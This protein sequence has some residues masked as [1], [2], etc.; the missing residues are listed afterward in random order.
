M[1][2][3]DV[4]ILTKGLTNQPYSYAG[5]KPVCDF[6]QTVVFSDRIFGNEMQDQ[7]L[8][9]RRTIGANTLSEEAKRGNDANLIR[10]K[11]ESATELVLPHYIHNL[12]KV[13]LADADVR[14]FGEPL[15]AGNSTQA[16]VMKKVIE[17]RN[18][19]HEMAVT[20][21]EKWCADTILDTAANARGQSVSGANLFTKPLEVFESARKV[22]FGKNA[23]TKFNLLVLNSADAIKFV[24]AMG[25]YIDKDTYDFGKFGFTLNTNGA[26]LV[27]VLTNTPAGPLSVYAYYGGYMDGSTFTPFLP[28]G[29]A[30][31]TSTQGVGAI[32]YGRVRAGNYY[33]V[34][35]ERTTVFED[36]MGDM[37]ATYIEYQSAPAPVI[38]FDNSYCLLTSIPASV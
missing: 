26:D 12:A 34:E 23:S 36:G 4:D 38:T 35:Q 7:V 24:T 27:G 20:S 1:A 17:K 6:L 15:D 29:S 19:L 21:I 33:T 16:R 5:K 31:L 11:D 30:I 9:E 8:I 28:Q 14:S 22:V 3:F 2:N 18:G 25:D 37:R 13:D 10:F 32:A